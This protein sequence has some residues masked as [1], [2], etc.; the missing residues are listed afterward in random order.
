ML[1]LGNILELVSWK[2]LGDAALGNILELVSWK[3]L[4]DAAW[5]TFFN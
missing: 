5:A 1:H 4:G 2:R 3:R